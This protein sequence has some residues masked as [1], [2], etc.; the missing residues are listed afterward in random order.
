MASGTSFLRISSRLLF[1]S[2]RSLNSF[3]VRLSSD[4]L[5]FFSGL[6]SVGLPKLHALPFLSGVGP[7]AGRDDPFSVVLLLIGFANVDCEEE[8]PFVASLEICC[9][10]GDL[11]ISD[12]IVG[13][14]TDA[15]SSSSLNRASA[16][17]GVDSF[18][19]ALASGL[20]AC[21]FSCVVDAAVL[22]GVRRSTFGS[23][24]SVFGDFFRS[25]SLIGERL[26]PLGFCVVSSCSVSVSES[27]ESD[28]DSLELESEEL[29]DD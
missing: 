1:W 23:T 15:G 14:K 12:L 28:P 26:G 18:S 13:G 4:T 22:G 2:A 20:F 25:A 27:L 11:A 21:P 29:E 6:G 3:N 8:P 19:E 17:R 24:T 9:S 10:F 16:S 7:L 5:S